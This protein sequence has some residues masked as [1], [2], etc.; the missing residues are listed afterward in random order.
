MTYG[1]SVQASVATPG[2]NAGH[3]L[4]VEAPLTSLIDAPAVLFVQ[5][6]KIL[7]ADGDTLMLDS[8]LLPV[9]TSMSPPAPEP[10]AVSYMPATNVAPLTIPVD[11][12]SQGAER[13]LRTPI[14]PLILECELANHPD[15]AFVRQLISDL[16]HGCCIGYTGPQFSHTSEHLSSAFEAPSVIDAN[17]K[18]K[19]AA[20]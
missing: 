16:Q 14:R 7:T 11:F 10:A 8:H 20:G 15:K 1:L 5:V 13:G 4:T 12:A 3:A 17:L 19:I 18:K 9:T 6:G 2:L